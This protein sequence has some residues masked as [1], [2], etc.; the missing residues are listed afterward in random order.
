MNRRRRREIEAQARQPTSV[1]AAVHTRMERWV[2]SRR[3]QPLIARWS[4]SWLNWRTTMSPPFDWAFHLLNGAIQLADR[5]FRPDR[6]DRVPCNRMRLGCL[7]RS[8]PGRSEA[9]VALLYTNSTTRETRVG[10]QP[11]RVCLRLISKTSERAAITF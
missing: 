1:A 8:H 3:R 2:E 5:Q 7:L 10:D 11:L 6:V 4:P 9:G